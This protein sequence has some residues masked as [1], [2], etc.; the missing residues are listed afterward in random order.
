MIKK[1]CLEMKFDIKK[2]QYFMFFWIFL[3]SKTVPVSSTMQ[4]LE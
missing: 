1:K 3:I 2:S 4:Q